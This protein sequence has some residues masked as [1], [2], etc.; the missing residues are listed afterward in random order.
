MRKSL[1]TRVQESETKVVELEHE[2]KKSVFKI[3]GL[4][5]TDE[6]SRREL[7]IALGNGS[8]MHY[9]TIGYTGY[10][11]RVEDKTQAMSWAQIFVQIGHLLAKRDYVE[12]KDQVGETLERVMRIE[13]DMR[14]NE[15]GGNVHIRRGH[16]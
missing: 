7:T 10:R 2:L 6:E 16:F 3:D 11:D 5:K 1:K 13:Q 4:L 9:P 15:T 8:T 14:D 12:F